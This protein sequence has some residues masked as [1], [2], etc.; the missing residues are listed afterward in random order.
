MNLPFIDALKA[1]ARDRLPAVR[2]VGTLRAEANMRDE[3]NFNDVVLT[4]SAVLEFSQRISEQ[5]LRHSR[6]DAIGHAKRRAVRVIASRL[7]GPVEDELRLALEELWADGMYDH[8]AT[9]RIENML[10]V[11]RGD[12]GE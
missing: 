9:K 5:V 6:A 11:L 1:T 3:P 4:H 7:Y 12:G 2:H 10:P 8:P